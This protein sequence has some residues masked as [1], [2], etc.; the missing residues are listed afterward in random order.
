ME[1]DSYEYRDPGQ[2][3][4]DVA[5]G[6]ALKE[7][8][9]LLALVRAPSTDQEVIHV[10]RLGRD[11]WVAVD[12]YTRS[13]LLCEAMRA[14]PVPDLRAAGPPR[15]SVMTIVARRGLTVLGGREGEW[16]MAWRY[17]HHLLAAFTGDLILVTEHGWTDFMTGWGG[18]EPRL[19]PELGV[20]R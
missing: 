3:L 10:S 19:T 20:F 5:A 14:M 9:G 11:E 2:V 13:Q 4:I 16:L 8:D 15:H 18:D 12:R 6:H 7:G 1:L 17:S